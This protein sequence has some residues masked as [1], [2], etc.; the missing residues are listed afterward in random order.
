MDRERA[1][2]FLRLLVEAELRR[3]TEQPGDF[4]VRAGCITR[5]IRVARVLT[6]VRALGDEVI[7]QVLDDFELALGRWQAWPPIWYGRG[8]LWLI[9]SSPSRRSPAAPDRAVPVGQVIPVHGEQVSGEV[10]VLSYAQTESGALLTIVARPGQLSPVDPEGP[11]QTM[12]GRPGIRRRGPLMIP[13]R[14]F[15]AADDQ[16]AT[17]Q[18]S[19]H[20]NGSWPREWTLRL[21]PD[22]P[23]DLSWLDL[24]TAP[25]EPAA[26]IDLTAAGQLPASPAV[27]IS[28]VTCRPAEQLLNNIA[29]RLLA[30]GAVFPQDIRILLS[31]F[32]GQPT[33]PLPGTADG[34][35]DVIAALQASGALPPVSP[36][37]GQL[38][39]LCARLNLTGHGITVPPARD[40]PE[41]W[42]GVLTQH[43]RTTMQAAPGCDGCAVVVAALPELD[44]IMLAILGLTSSAD[45]TILHVHASGPAHQFYYGPPERNLAPTIWIR[46]SRGRWHATRVREYH[47]GDITMHL[48]VVPPLSHGTAWIEV[49]VAGQP[50]E[51]RATLPLRWQ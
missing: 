38:A 45:G 18:M 40:L 6:A 26:R 50:A 31:E 9:G 2:T 44:G 46:D 8:L 17:Y 12:P 32:A 37:P 34:L 4:A 35:G 11:W 48:Q 41:P 25:G 28:Q 1:E 3:L 24:S 47:E 16:G 27:T 14:Q 39:A 22:P 29:L 51:V 23:R 7:G 5:V 33:G 30:T 42:L 19:Y 49:L 15:A 20:G 36:L 21:Y 13:F 10:T 43:E